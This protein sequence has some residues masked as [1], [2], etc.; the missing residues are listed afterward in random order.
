MRVTSGKRAAAR[1]TVVLR[2]AGKRYKAKTS[3]A[4]IARFTIP[5]NGKFV[6]ISVK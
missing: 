4:G 2:V 5:A 3:A 1:R 6:V